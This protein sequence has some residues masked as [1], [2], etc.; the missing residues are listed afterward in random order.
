MWL[1]CFAILFGKDVADVDLEGTFD[2]FSLLQTFAPNS[3]SAV[4]YPE[5]L[6]VVTAMLR[7]GLLHLNKALPEQDAQLIDKANE[8]NGEAATLRPVSHA[9]QR[10]LT[11]SVDM[12]KICKLIFI[13]PLL[14]LTD[15]LEATLKE[16]DDKLT[17][18][19]T[20][21]HIVTRFLA[22]IHSRSQTFRDFT[23]TSTY[24]QELFL[25]LFP[26]IVSSNTVSADTEL[27]SRDAS[28]TFKGEDVTMK[29]VSAGSISGAPTV[30]TATPD[31]VRAPRGS[32]PQAP[33][34]MSSYILVTSEAGG[35]GLFTPKLQTVV[36]PR[37]SKPQLDASNIMIEAVLELA[38][39]VFCDQI[40]A[41]KDFPGLGLFMRVPPG[42]QEHQAYFETFI[43]RN[44]L[45]HISNGIKLDQKLLW[46]PRVLSNIARLAT[47]LGEAI[48]E[49]WFIDGCDDTFD[50]LANILEYLQLPDVASIKS[51]RLCS[52]TIATIRT[53]LF[54]VVLMRLSE[55]DES[56][57]VPTLVAFLNKLAYWQTVLLPPQEGGDDFLRLFSYLLYS[58]LD[59]P[60]EQV[61]FAA[62][63]LWRLL[64]VHKSAEISEILQQA[65]DHESEAL[66]KGF[67]KIM[68]LD[69]ETFLAWLDDHRGR[70]D[71]LVFSSLAKS[72]SYFVTEEN[73][74]TEETARARVSKRRERLRVWASDEL[75]NEEM[76]RRHETS[77]EHW[78]SNIYTAENIK[79]Q[80][81][82]QDDLDGK[83]FNT[84]SW[85]K[86]CEEL[87]RSCGLL[88]DG[89]IPK[90]QL[91]QTE[92]RNRMRMRFIPIRD[93]CQHDYQPKRRQSQGRVRHR[94]S[95]GT[96]STPGKDAPALPGQASSKTDGSAEPNQ[97]SEYSEP[98]VRMENEEEEFEMVSDPRAEAE[99]YEDKN[100]KV[101]RSLQR[102]DQVEHVHNTSRIV[103]LEAVEGLLIVGKGHLY[104]LDNLFQRVDGEI[105]NVMHAP[106]EERDHYLQMISGRETARQSVGPAKTDFETRSWRWDEILSISKRRF[107]FRD[108]AIEVFF[109]D[110]RSYLL[111]TRNPNARNEIYQKLLNKASSSSDGGSSL[112]KE[113]NW[114]IDSLRDPEE[115][116]QSLGSRFTNVFCPTV[117]QF[118]HA[119]VAQRRNIEFPL[120]N[121][122]QHHGWANVQRFDPVPRLSL[123][124]GGLY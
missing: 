12:P 47:H 86:M 106:P 16:A 4:M 52:Q 53:L 93:S 121:A 21:I 69:N 95:V 104:L 63:N 68:E 98:S 84:A 122:D 109:I 112:N 9:R 29:P 75:K 38:L 3:K 56:T 96:S 87:S 14:L 57:S 92:G 74:R 82:L 108:V 40:F 11:L 23:A 62:S 76:I 107:L 1:I 26:V 28:L 119:K 34:R 77:S 31:S 114:R 81:A 111:T 46:E 89:A 54:R 35:P 32:K 60:E 83:A 80:R 19:V 58:R 13:I 70:L 124:S 36:S 102:G 101:M 22:D 50:F 41:R 15:T 18:G 49:G 17:S 78:R 7:G 39:A 59:S 71:R 72:W 27:N 24:I 118:R 88:D 116:S 91:D 105:V 2:L 33:K 51:V 123:G 61:R 43:L 100:R 42:F 85:N 90:W 65:G 120:L 94:S 115:D 48:Y 5:I 6:P 10:S 110:G 103:G 25:V 44:S 73:R 30:R 113:E 8:I 20:V 66:I 97:T 117:F 45:S 79:R 64:L 99:E 55:L 67:K 37:R